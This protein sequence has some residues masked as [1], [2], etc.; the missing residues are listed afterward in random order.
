LSQN[1][2][3]IVVDDF[4][5][6]KTAAIVEQF[7]NQNQGHD[8][9]L[10]KMADQPVTEQNSF[11]KAAITLAIGMSEYNWVITSDADCS[12]GTKWLETIASFIEENDPVL[13]S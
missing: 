10:I 7:I 9:K 13:V 11:K 5:E 4:S 2:E 1:F 6:D 3:I 12:R 8:I